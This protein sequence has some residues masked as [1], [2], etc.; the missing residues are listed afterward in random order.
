VADR[1]AEQHMQKP[2]K[3]DEVAVLRV[4]REEMVRRLT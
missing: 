2:D 1:V 3:I 4:D